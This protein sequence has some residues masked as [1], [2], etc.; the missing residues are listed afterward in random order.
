MK[1]LLIINFTMDSNNPV[2]SHQVVAVEKL[3][4]DFHQVIVLTADAGSY[5]SHKN[6]RVVSTYWENGKPLTNVFSIFQSYK[7]QFNRR[8]FL[9]YDRF[10]DGPIGSANANFGNE[11]LS[12]VCA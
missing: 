3:A 2:L 7:N 5:V 1:N 12:L 10:T 9:P 11:A 6:I 4:P 8:R